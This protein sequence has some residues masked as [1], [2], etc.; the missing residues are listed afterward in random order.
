[1]TAKR[2]AKPERESRWEI[3][4]AGDWI[5]HDIMQAALQDFDRALHH[6]EKAWG[7]DRL[8]LLVSQETRLKWWKAVDALN[9]ARFTGNAD[10]VKTLAANLVKGLQHLEDEALTANRKTLDPEIWETPLPDGRVLRVVRTWPE[11]AHSP[12]SDPN[13]VTYTLEEVGR[14]LG[15]Q[16]FLS[17]VKKEWPAAHV[18]EVRSPKGDLNDDIP[19]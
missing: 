17:A 19:F 10:R 6:T 11:R 18:T 3:R 2:V 5:A 12:D 9:E 8:P 15:S 13:V 7:V 1:M 4:S 14:L 16:A